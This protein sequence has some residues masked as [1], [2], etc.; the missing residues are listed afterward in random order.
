M[1]IILCTLSLTLALLT[2]F[3]QHS[4]AQNASGNGTSITVT[5]PVKSDS[6]VVIVG[7][8]EAHNFMQNPSQ[9]LE[10]NIEDG[11]ATVT[12]RDVPQGEYAIVLFHDTNG[13]KRMDFETNGMPLEM[14]GVS[15]NVMSMGPPQW[16]DA[17]FEVKDQPLQL[18]IRL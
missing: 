11:K 13:N 9:G 6:G 2:G 10:G 14:Y 17:K 18:E 16:S 15:N 5:V 3:G 8:Y 1:K 7:L 12:F 4:A